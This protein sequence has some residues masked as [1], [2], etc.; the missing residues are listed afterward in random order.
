M[1]SAPAI[2]TNY[3]FAK[4]EACTLPTIYFFDS[5]FIG[6]GR[7]EATLGRDIA[8]HNFPSLSWTGTPLP[9]RRR[10]H[11][12]TCTPLTVAPLAAVSEDYKTVQEEYYGSCVCFRG[13]LQRMGYEFERWSQYRSLPLAYSLGNVESSGR[14]ED[15][16]RRDIDVHNFRLCKLDMDVATRAPREVTN[17][18]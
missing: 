11:S 16:L 7:R 4:E 6:C 15:T 10:A 5:G 12:Q 1:P 13:R 17:C 2:P 18:T 3:T 9:R 8:V 14:R